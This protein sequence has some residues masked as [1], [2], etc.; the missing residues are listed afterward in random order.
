M[1]GVDTA[2]VGFFVVLVPLGFWVWALV[3]FSRTDERDM[4][5]FTKPMWIVVLVLL[6]VLGALL[7]W[8]VGRADRVRR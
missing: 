3:D 1:H 5:T 7:W 6:N 8:A 4:R 2:Y